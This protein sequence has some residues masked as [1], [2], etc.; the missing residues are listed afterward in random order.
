MI[1]REDML[2]LTR[3]M[4]L[5]RHCLSRAAGAYFDENGEIDGTFNTHFLKLSPASA[6]SNL[7]LAKTIPFSGTNRQLKEYLFPGQDKNARQLWQLLTELKR[8]SLKNDAL[9][10]VLYD[11][12][13]ER[14]PKGEPSALILFSGSYDVPMKASDK[15]RLWESEEVYDFLI[16]AFCS[17]KA[18]YEPGEAVFGFLFPAFADRTADDEHILIYTRP[19]FETVTGGLKELFTA[20]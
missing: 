4:T 13:A 16:C 10:D 8:C 12:A 18:P 11:L 19:G 5:K 1:N 7:A 2:E 20:E 17:L 15:E 9:L 14:I 6:S 3:R